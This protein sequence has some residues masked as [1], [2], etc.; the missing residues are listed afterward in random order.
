MLAAIDDL[1]F[2][3]R[4]LG[5]LAKNAAFRLAVVLSR[6]RDVGIAPGRPDLVHRSGDRRSKNQP[7]ESRQ[8]LRVPIFTENPVLDWAP[9]VAR[10]G[11]PGQFGPSIRV[12]CLTP[13]R[14]AAAV[15]RRILRRSPESPL[16]PVRQGI[17]L[18]SDQ[19]IN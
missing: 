7:E 2:W 15:Y 19:P 3:I 18:L 6:R 8:L 10:Q 5:K 17:L 1:C 16:F 13:K 9:L 14:V 11:V 12:V 4:Q